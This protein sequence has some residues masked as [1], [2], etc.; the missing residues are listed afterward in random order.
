M[1]GE[2]SGGEIE[3]RF[4]LL[5]QLFFHL[6]HKY[7]CHCEIWTEWNTMNVFQ[8]GSCE[9]LPPYL[10]H[11]WAS[12]SSWLHLWLSETAMNTFSFTDAHWSMLKGGVNT[13]QTTDW[14][15]GT[16]RVVSSSM[17]WSN[18]SLSTFSAIFCLAACSLSQ[19]KLVF[20]VVMNNTHVLC[21]ENVWSS[22]RERVKIS[23]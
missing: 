18:I 9:K 11:L 3:P 1:I 20:L 22:K 2:L 10:N 4:Q 19:V 8:E 5:S 17:L 16:A 21:V 14:S 6:L 15:V 12:S 13:L 7:F 23:S